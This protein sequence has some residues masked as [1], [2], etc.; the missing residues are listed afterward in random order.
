[1]LIRQTMRPVIAGVGLGM[2]GAYWAAQ[3]LQAFLVDVPARDPWIYGL[4]A[5]VIFTV[6]VAAVWIPV[7]RAALTDPAAVL[8]AQ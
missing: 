3:F 5:A 7:R 6:T 8:R 4:V 2:A 1:M